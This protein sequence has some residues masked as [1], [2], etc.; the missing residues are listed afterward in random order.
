MS[1]DLGVDFIDQDSE[2][3]KNIKYNESMSDDDG[4][5]IGN[6]YYTNSMI[7]EAAEKMKNNT[8]KQPYNIIFNPYD[9]D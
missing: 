3:A 5:F 9:L 4:I 6:C 7:D 1:I 8:N 2:C